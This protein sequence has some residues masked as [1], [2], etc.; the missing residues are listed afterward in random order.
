MA[1]QR[2]EAVDNLAEFWKTGA[3]LA[4]ALA[5]LCSCAPLPTGVVDQVGATTPVVLSAGD[6][7]R[8]SFT[9]APEYNQTQKI[10]SDGKIS[11][12]QI[13]EVTAA[14]KTVL[15]FES[16]VRAVYSD[17]MKDSDVTVTVES[18]AIQVYVTGAVR[19][20]GKQVF[21]RPMTILQ[22]IMEAGG[23]NQYGNVGSVRLIRTTNGVHRTQI[24]DLR[25]AMAGQPT[26]AM[27]VKNGDIIKVPESPF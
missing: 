11:L 27:Y 16:Q 18:A 10:R 1:L 9:A 24:V 25:P 19:S 3:V 20:P 7:V 17:L 8:I 23:P 4:V 6:T 21:D 15:Q 14:G 26:N 22:A 13:G 12:P 5:F 2:L